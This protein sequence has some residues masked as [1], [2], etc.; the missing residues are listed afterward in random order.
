MVISPAAS[1]A[2]ERK[3]SF[4]GGV[5]AAEICVTPPRI[6]DTCEVEYFCTDIS[7]GRGK[8]YAVGRM[9]PPMRSGLK[10]E[11]GTTP[12]SK[13]NKTNNVYEQLGIMT[14]IQ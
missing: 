8:E 9:L 2:R 7:G 11:V 13:T 10:E 4:D 1:L 12:R 3:V 5:G 6:G 14:I